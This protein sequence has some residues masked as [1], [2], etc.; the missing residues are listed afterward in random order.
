M[1]CNSNLNA[2]GG[3]LK[4]ECGLLILSS[5]VMLLFSVFIR[6]PLKAQDAFVPIYSAKGNIRFTEQIEQKPVHSQ[7]WSYVVSEDDRG[8]W[9]IVLRG[10]AQ[11]GKV[12]IKTEK[13]IVYDGTNVYS[14]N[15]SDVISIDPVN[16]KKI[17][18]IDN[19]EKVCVIA[20]PSGCLHM[21][22]R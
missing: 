21:T 16:P 3:H 2:N 18:V 19:L 17:T 9:K 12:P 7:L 4:K 13:Q 15:A 8:R 11:A 14:L 20:L 6:L 5:F 22:R 1:R 10:S